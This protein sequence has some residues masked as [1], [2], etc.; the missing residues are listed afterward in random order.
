[1]SGLIFLAVFFGLIGLAALLG[2]TVDSREPGDWSPSRDGR[3][4]TPC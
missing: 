1:M 4:T 3:R 2:L